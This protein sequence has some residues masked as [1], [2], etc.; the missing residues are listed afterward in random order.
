MWIKFRNS[1]AG[2]NGI[3]NPGDVRDWPEASA[4][5][6]IASHQAVEVEAPRA[7]AKPEPVK[8]EKKEALK[9]VE[10]S[11]MET[12]EDTSWPSKR[13]KRVPEKIH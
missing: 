12:P 3:I 1:G 8:E 13:K 11:T 10:T 6:L 9:P 4:L 2:P 5:Q 7:A